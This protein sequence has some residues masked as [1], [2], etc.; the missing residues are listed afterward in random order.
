MPKLLHS[1]VGRVSKEAALLMGAAAEVFLEALT[2]GCGASA[3]NARPKRRTIKVQ[4]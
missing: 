4:P 2:E 1:Q 3:R